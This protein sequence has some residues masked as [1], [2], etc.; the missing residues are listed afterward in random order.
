MLIS[1]ITLVEESLSDIVSKLIESSDEWK[2]LS[3]KM[4]RQFSVEDA[5]K[6]TKSTISAWVCVEIKHGDQ[7]S[8]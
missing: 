1:F 5:D 6:K 2:T 3:N 4:K 7:C 8:C